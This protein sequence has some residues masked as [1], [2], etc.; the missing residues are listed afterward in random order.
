MLV[1]LAFSLLCCSLF[2]AV[3]RS[4]CLSPSL[5]FSLL[6]ACPLSLSPIGCF[7]VMFRVLGVARLERTD[8][9]GDVRQEEWE[10]RVLLVII[11]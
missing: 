11:R 3:S 9:F 1:S 10:R 2:L 6:L 8:S 5:S 4:F 7:V